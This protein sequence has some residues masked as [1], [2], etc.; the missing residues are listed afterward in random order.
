M[1]QDPELERALHIV[2]LMPKVERDILLAWRE[3]R[4]KLIEHMAKVKALKDSL[5]ANKPRFVETIPNTSLST[6]E[7]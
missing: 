2:D 1:S 4:V 3:Y 5:D 6:V 7:E